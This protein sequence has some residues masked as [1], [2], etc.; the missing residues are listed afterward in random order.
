MAARHAHAPP[1]RSRRV[2][3]A[4]SRRVPTLSAALLALA[5]ALISTGFF[6]AS[7]AWAGVPPADGTVASGAPDRP[8]AAAAGLVRLRAPD[9]D[10]MDTIKTVDAD[11]GGSLK[12][13][14]KTKQVRVCD[15]EEDGHLVR[16][17]VIADGNEVVR[18]RAGA[19]GK[20]YVK[21][22]EG[23]KAAE[24]Y[25]FK[26]CLAK[27]DEEPDGYC[28]FSTNSTW[29]KAERN[30]G[31]CDGIDDAQEKIECVGG[32]NEYC[33]LAWEVD[34]MFP[35]H[36]KREHGPKEETQALKPPT[37]RKPDVNARPDASLPRG[38][39]AKAPEITEPLR[40][41]LR[42]L[43]WTALGACVL[44]FILVGGKMALKHK[45]AEA[46]AY[47]AELGWVAVACVMAGSGLAIAFISLLID[48][49]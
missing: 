37:G 4:S 12:W 29:P 25:I 33:S 10:E 9:W 47:A 5:F 7:A 14:P 15:D 32:V 42:W 6:G 34:A 20:C 41:V 45:R 40:P 16:G 38:H 31:H 21:R 46:G 26:I 24:P 36:C 13:D 28:N 18:I 30:E 39:A 3:M 1:G 49:L 35:E 22:V 27:S 17:Y 2:R 48:P 43:V 23:Y 44:G 11:P 8:R 19:K